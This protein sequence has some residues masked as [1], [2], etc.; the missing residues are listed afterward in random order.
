[1]VLLLLLIAMSVPF[2]FVLARSPLIRRLSGRHTFGR[3]VEA[4]LVIA[5]SLLG[6]AIITGS[7]I[8]GDTINRSIRAAAYDQ[9]G[10]IDELVS[11]PLGSR[12]ATEARLTALRTPQIDG[13]LTMTTTAAAVIRPGAGGGTQPRAQLLEV[14]FAKARRFGGDASATG[15]SG[16]TPRFGAAAVTNDLARRLDLRIGS[17]IIAF[18]GGGRVALTVDRILPRRGVAGFWTID[19]RQQ[20]YNVFVTPGT[21]AQLAAGTPQ[22]A[23][24]ETAAAPPQ[25]V[26]VVSNVGGVES[27]ASRTAD[28]LRAIDRQLEGLPARA[29]PVKRDL[30]ARADKAGQSLSQLYFTIGMFAVAAGVLLLVNVFVM[31]ADERR[32]ELGMLRA[33]GMRRRSLVGAL[34]SEGWLYAVPASAIGAVLGIGFGWLIAWRA[35]EILSSGREVTALHL[36][37]TFQASTVLTG[38]VVGFAIALATILVSSIRIARF[39]VIQAIRDIH[40]P[41]VRRPR[42][43]AAWVGFALVLLGVGATVMGATGPNPYTLMLGPM[44]VA[45]G[46]APELARHLPARAVYTGVCVVVIGWGVGCFAVLAALD[47][48]V[49]IP[50][51]LVQGLSLVAAAVYLATA[52]LRSIGGVL[53]RWS[54][55]ALA[56]RLGLAYPL[57]RRFRTAMTLGMFAVIVMTLVYMSEISFMNQGRT[58]EIA[59]NLSGGF[60]I[61]VLSNPGDPV[62]SA[63]LLSLPGVERVA[64]LGYVVGEFSTPHRARTPWPA[65]GVGADLVAAPPRLRNRGNYASDRAAWHAIAQNPD[66]MIIDDFFLQAA[67]GPSTRAATIGDPVVM[68]DP[69]S[70]RSHTFRV[71][72]I[73]ENDFLGNGAFVD[74]AALTKVVRERAVPSRFFVAATNPD[75]TARRIRSEFVA[76]GADAA[77]VRSIVAAGQS[78]SSGFF[79]L[80]EQ[81]VGVGLLVGV[82]GVGVIMFR[83]VRERRREVG[84]LRSLGFQPSSVARA[85]MFE[86]GFVA[87]LGVVIGV[88]IALVA[89]YVLAVSGADFA[90]GYQFGVP[91]G[92]V[93]VIMAVALVP[94][95]LAAALPARQASRIEPAVALRVRE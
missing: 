80:L 66:L 54:G 73:A 93:L 90:K 39:N 12:G 58:D 94:A 83:A 24:A 15:M 76:H 78:Q 82:A 95:V 5:G 3:P 56:A 65:T 63:Q 17:R 62:T 14:D 16:P 37:F 85:F 21:I 75:A 61:D 38:F 81:F 49:E 29:Q 88:V 91:V 42:R 68:Y 77:T 34:A 87:T 23:T 7:L 33:M 26:T 84:V 50:I 43:R 2:A 31:L 8:V 20:S 47:A 22:T 30:L 6:T 52:Y 19:P 60:G 27:G 51:F 53:E 44:L 10:P 71:A 1:V 36:T 4:L 48:T 45:V 46:V 59:Q 41:A 28:A 69:S 35:D 11:V 79:T 70:G 57:A 18:A 74:E 92:E 64:P 67:G 25:S 32:S 72:A 89:T 13:I 9:L 55:G 86:A 40:A